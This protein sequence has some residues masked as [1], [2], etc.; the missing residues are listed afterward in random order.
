MKQFHFISCF[1]FIT[2]IVILII[3]NILQSNNNISKFD[4]S[5]L[6][7]Q[8]GIV[9][10]NYLPNNIKSEYLR[11]ILNNKYNVQLSKKKIT[12]EKIRCSLYNT[13][14]LLLFDNFFENIRY[15]KC[16]IVMSSGSLK[17]SYHG[18]EINLHDMVL[19]FNDA[20]IKNF[21]QDVGS[22]TT[23]RIV[24]SR[25][26]FHSPNLINNIREDIFIWDPSKYNDTIETWINNTEFNFFSVLKKIRKKNIH[27]IHPQLLWKI[28]NVIQS[29]FDDRIQ[30]N[31]PSSGMIGIVIS[32]HICDKITIYEFI[33][34]IERN[35]HLCY[36]WKN[37][38]DDACIFGAYHPLI[39]EKGIIRK[40][41]VGSENDIN[42][43]ILKLNG[44]LYNECKN[45]Y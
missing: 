13:N 26:V 41:H 34:S 30:P 8:K 10:I 37:I 40:L 32:M 24:N 31:P 17:G 39:F 28:W 25:L 16:A 5:F 12:T 42:R 23:F 43:G 38:Y 6:N 9:K 7:L 36:Y 21:E 29:S 3:D 1:C 45:Y 15:N 11:Y 27:V 18:N 20:K 33:P 14:K 19:R 4:I 35:K 44:L 2:V 22:K